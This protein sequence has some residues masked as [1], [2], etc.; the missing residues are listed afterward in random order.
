MEEPEY[1]EVELR[2]FALINEAREQHGLA[3]LKFNSLVYQCAKTRVEEVNVLWSH[4]RPDGRA[5]HTV[6]TDREIEV[7]FYKAAEN[8]CKGGQT[9]ESMMQALMNSEG[10]RKNI[11]NPDMSEVAIC[12]IPMQENPQYY[13]MVQLFLKPRT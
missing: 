11:L 7:Y 3:P 13:V 4:T 6:F 8:L 9:A 10:H 5:W 2:T 12:I 1:S